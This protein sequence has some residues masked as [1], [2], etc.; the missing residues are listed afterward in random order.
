MPEDTD[1]RILWALRGIGLLL[2]ALLIAIIG[3]G[4]RSFGFVLAALFVAVFGVGLTFR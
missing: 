3:I 2:F 4:E 1:K